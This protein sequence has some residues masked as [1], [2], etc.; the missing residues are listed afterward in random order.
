MPNDTLDASALALFANRYSD[1][2]IEITILTSS[3]SAS[4]SKS[5]EVFFWAA[6]QTFLAYVDTQ[7]GE[8]KKGEGRIEWPLSEEQHA[9][10]AS[11]AGLFKTEHIYRLK[12]RSLLNKTVPEGVRPSFSNRFMLIKIIEENSKNSTL[13]EFLEEYK[14]PVFLT[15][16]AMGSFTLN[17]Q[18]RF[19]EGKIEWC[20]ETV[21][22]YLD[23]E[24]DDEKTW[25]NSIRTLRTL[26]DAQASYDEQFRTFAAEQLTEKANEWNGAEEEPAEEISEEIFADR[27]TVSSLSVSQS[28][29][30]IVYYNDDDLFWGHVIAVFGNLYDGL[31][32]AGI[33]G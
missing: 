28:G 15:D 14:K 11:W 10:R 33:E 22:A 18:L 25:K 20:E 4:C 21:A 19:F 26:F 1:E 17:K 2:D 9:N 31:K 16:E 32:T 23:V 3:I 29:D 24:T 5:K 27:I 12:V 6:S 13:R 30:F 7:T 8:L